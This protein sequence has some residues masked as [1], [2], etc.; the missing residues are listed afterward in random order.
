MRRK[1]VNG[2]DFHR[3]Y[4]ISPYVVDFYRPEVRLAIQLDGR[5]LTLCEILPT[6]VPEFCIFE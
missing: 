1:Q 6:F 2:D 5:S 4:S 3:Q